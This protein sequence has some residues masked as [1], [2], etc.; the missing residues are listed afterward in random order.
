MLPGVPVGEEIH[1][2]SCIGAEDGPAGPA[3][4]GLEL[5]NTIDQAGLNAFRAALVATV[6]ALLPPLGPVVGGAMVASSDPCQL[7]KPVLMPTGSLTNWTPTILPFQLLRVGP[8][9]IAGVPG[10]MTMQ[11]GR[12]LRDSL[13]VVLAPLGVQRVVITGESS[14]RTGPVNELVK[15]K[16]T[17]TQSQT[18]GKAGLN[19]VRPGT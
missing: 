15:A 14:P 12:R 5:G 10:E 9:A 18:D 1:G 4:E 8:L 11:A 6:S 13:M 16:N 19:P 17:N 7:P 3:T 2:F